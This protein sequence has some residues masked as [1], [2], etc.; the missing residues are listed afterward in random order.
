MVIVS[1]FLKQEEHY[2]GSSSYPAAMPLLPSTALVTSVSPSFCSK[3]RKVRLAKC[4]AVE[5]SEK[6]QEKVITISIF[7]IERWVAISFERY[8]IRETNTQKKEKREKKKNSVF[9]TCW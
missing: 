2:L 6:V 7:Q 5:M 8:L 4:W 3:P 9:S 1:F